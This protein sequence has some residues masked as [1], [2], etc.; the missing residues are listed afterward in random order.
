MAYDQLSR[1]LLTNDALVLIGALGDGNCA[2]YLLQ[3]VQK[4][5]A[6]CFG[7]EDDSFG[8]F[9]DALQALQALM[10]VR[11]CLDWR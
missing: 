3:F 4:L 9:D 6:L 11:R 5:R 1:M 8:T 2:F 7:V 10:I